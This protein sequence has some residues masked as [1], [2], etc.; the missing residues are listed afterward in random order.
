[1]ASWPSLSG[2]Y[3]AAVYLVCDSRRP[4]D[5]AMVAYFRRRAVADAVVAGVVAVVGIFVLRSDARYLFGGLTA[6]AL[7]LVIVSAMS[8]TASLV[9]LVRGAHQWARCCP[10]GPSPAS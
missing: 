7:P 1:M 9:L 6:R 4:G 2:A 10:S 5:P 8:G 3:L